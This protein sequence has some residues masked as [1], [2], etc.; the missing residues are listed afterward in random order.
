MSKTSMP[1]LVP[2]RCY[3]FFREYGPYSYFYDLYGPLHTSAYERDDFVLCAQFLGAYPPDVDLKSSWGHLF[4]MAS[5]GC[6]F[7]FVFRHVYV[8]EPDLFLM[9]AKYQLLASK[10]QL[11]DLSFSPSIFHRG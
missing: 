10:G 7:R 4:S 3:W 9:W 2:G 8:I 1:D 11:F 6:V 5:G